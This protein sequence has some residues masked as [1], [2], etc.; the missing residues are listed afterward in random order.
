MLFRSDGEAWEEPVVLNLPINLRAFFDSET[1]ANFFAVTMIGYMFRNPDVSFETLLGKISRQM[2][3]KI[4]KGRLEE[5]ISYTVSREKKWYIRVIPLV[6]KRLALDLVFRLKDRAYT[7]TLSNVGVIQM[8]PEYEEEI[9]RF[10]LMI[11]V[12]RR[13]PIKCAVCSYGKEAVIT[14]TSVFSDNHLPRR[15]FDKLKE[16]GIRVQLEGNEPSSARKRDMY[17]SEEHTSNSSH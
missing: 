8:E 3:R 5:S 9:E 15:F 17:R 12:S 10:H 7:M 14:F 16:D 4:D 13:Q 1:M 6:L 11:G 2:D